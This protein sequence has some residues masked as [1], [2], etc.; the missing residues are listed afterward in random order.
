MYYK[1]GLMTRRIGY[2]FWRALENSLGR[3]WENQRL[4]RLPG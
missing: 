4:R 2:I 1:G 3:D